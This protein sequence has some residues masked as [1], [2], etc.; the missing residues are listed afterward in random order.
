MCLLFY[1]HKSSQDKWL[2]RTNHQRSAY[3]LLQ[4]HQSHWSNLTKCKD[5]LFDCSSPSW[6][7]SIVIPEVSIRGEETCVTGVVW[8]HWVLQSP[9][10]RPPAQQQVSP[11]QDPPDLTQHTNLINKQSKGYWTASI[12]K[13]NSNKLDNIFCKLGHKLNRKVFPFQFIRQTKKENI[14]F[15][16]WAG[17]KFRAV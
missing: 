1:L 10:S 17:T 9:P 8:P 5:F 11:K 3:C 14:I 4:S 13:A 12:G 7:W 2:A 16:Q 6:Y 15:P